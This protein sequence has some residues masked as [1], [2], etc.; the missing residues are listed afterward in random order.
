MIFIKNDYIYQTNY[1]AVNKLY[2]K[3]ANNNKLNLDI[4]K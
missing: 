2:L 3:H 4:F 1:Q